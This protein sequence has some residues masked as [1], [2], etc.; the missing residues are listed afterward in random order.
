MT[1]M[2]DFEKMNW[3][4]NHIHNFHIREGDD[5]WSGILELDI[6]YI[7]EWQKTDNKSFN[8]V[9]C[10]ATLSFFGVTDLA[11][12]IDYAKATARVQP[13]MIYDIH[14]EVKNFPNGYST[15]IW[16]I[17]LGWPSNGFISFS[18]SEFTQ[19]LR[20]KPKVSGSQYLLPAERQVAL[21][22]THH[23]SGTPNGAP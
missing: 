7:I 12:S 9:V 18:A 8:F 1:V 23:S 15:Y 4:D 5:E 6:D 14:R 2:D 17:E 16:N 3:H 22:L 19:V 13:M 10:P 21:N 11:V 20:G